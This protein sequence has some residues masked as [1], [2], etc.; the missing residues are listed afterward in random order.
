MPIEPLP[1]S[2]EA[3]AAS[4]AGAGP[5]ADSLR[6]A[7]A[8]VTARLS[9][10]LTSLL[11]A[12]A[13]AG[14]GVLDA[15]TGELRVSILYVVVIGL[16]TWVNGR[17]NGLL[18]ATACGAVVLLA[19]TIG[20]GS[21]MADPRFLV[22]AGSDLLVFGFCV[23]GTNSLREGLLRE[24]ARRRNLARYLPAPFAEQLA[25]QGLRALTT[26]SCTAA[27]L[28]VDIRG[29]TALSRRMPPPMVFDLLK[30]YRGIVTA[31]VQARGGFVDKF[32]GD[33]ALA[34]FGADGAAAGICAAAAVA[35][36]LEILARIGRG[37]GGPNLAIGIGVHLGDVIIGALGDDERLEFTVLGDTVNVAARIEDL[38]R[39]LGLPLL[40]SEAVYAALPPELRTGHSWALFCVRGVH[41]LAAPLT[42]AYPDRPVEAVPGKIAY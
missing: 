19:N 36:A 23:I 9:P 41:G 38:T 8:A 39:D 30:T 32:V 14:I 27:I 16:M 40:V 35:A 2:V 1:N 18:F 42:L 5:L 29:F 24:R 13:V 20:G 11:G 3:S 22:S 10:I 6:A 37:D 4:G 28:F 7:G 25:N 31:A 33:G 21:S 34:V 17:E 12:L 26:R 15:A